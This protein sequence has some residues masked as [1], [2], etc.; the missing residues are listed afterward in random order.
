MP[1]APTVISSRTRR[2]RTTP[3]HGRAHELVE[4]HVDAVW[5]TLRRLGMPTSDL[6]DGVQQVFMVA[7]RRVDNI[8]PGKERSFLLGVAVRVVSDHRR[9]RRRHPE[10]VTEPVDLER[11]LH[12]DWAPDRLLDDRQRLELLDRLIAQLPEDLAT[13]FVLHELEE[14]TMAQIA[15]LLGLVQGTVA[16]RLR[17]ARERFE[18]LCGQLEAER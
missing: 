14:L 2:A 11:H 17:R 9:T 18:T 10:D 12:A 1:D 7:A 3:G 13:V 16:S 5:R 15:E 6:D 8:E 4:E